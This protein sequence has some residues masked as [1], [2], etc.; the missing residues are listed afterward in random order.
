M[1]RYTAYTLIIHS[2]LA[3]PEICQ[4]AATNT[5]PDIIIR[6]AGQPVGQ[7]TLGRRLAQIGAGE[8]VEVQVVR[9]GERTTVPVTLGERP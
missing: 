4:A 3:L 1:Y 2:E 6:I 8:T 9:D 7:R 5:A